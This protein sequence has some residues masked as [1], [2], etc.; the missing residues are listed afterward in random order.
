[1]D[2]LRFRIVGLTQERVRNWQ[3]RAHPGPIDRGLRSRVTRAWH[4][5]RRSTRLLILIGSIAVA[6][7]AL[8]R[9]SVQDITGRRVLLLLDESGSMADTTERTNRQLEALKTNNRFVTYP[10]GTNGF[11]ISATHAGYSMLQPL[12]A[13]L[14]ANPNVDTVYFISDFKFGDE[15]DN[16]AAGYQ[17]LR[18]LVRSHRVTLYLATVD[19]P[20]PLPE[21]YA[22]PRASGGGVI[23]EYMKPH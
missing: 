6:Y 7:A 11:A 13:A 8:A 16:D 1:M 18:E 5:M 19:Q 4:A 9:P 15:A 14:A 23:E 22:I 20:P 10:Y 2:E 17:A 21:Y 3:K 12:E